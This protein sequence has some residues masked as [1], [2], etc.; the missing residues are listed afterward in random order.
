MEVDAIRLETDE[1]RQGKPADAAS[2]L[3]E[4]EI[5]VLGMR[6]RPDQKCREDRE[7]RREGVLEAHAIL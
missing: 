2:L 7:D 5:A 1:P 4:S 6:G 3:A